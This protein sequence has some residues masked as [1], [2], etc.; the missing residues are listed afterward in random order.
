MT[1]R[2]KNYDYGECDICDALMEGR[3]IKQDFWVRGELIVIEDV[4]AGVCPRCGEKIVNAAVERRIA[5]IIENKASLLNAPKLLVPAIK[6]ADE[7]AGV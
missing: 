6:Y 1:T 2:F 5:E 7:Q 4:P 3:Q